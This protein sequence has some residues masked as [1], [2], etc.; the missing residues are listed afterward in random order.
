MQWFNKLGLIRQRLRR[1]EEISRTRPDLV[2]STGLNR[3]GWYNALRRPEAVLAELAEEIEVVE[4]IMEADAW[5]GAVDDDD[6][7]HEENR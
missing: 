4:S 1:L 2:S 5:L 7:G 3:R 6:D